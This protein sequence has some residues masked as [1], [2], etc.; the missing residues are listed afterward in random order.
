MSSRISI[1]TGASGGLGK[2]IARDLSRYGHVV[3]VSS[4]NPETLSRASEEGQKD[5]G[6]YMKH[7]L[8]IRD[9][10]QVNVLIDKVLEKY[11]RIDVLVNSAGFVHPRLDLENVKHDDLLDCFETNVFGL[12]YLLQRVVPIM[13]AQK[14]GVIINIASKSARFAV[15]GLGVY[16]ASKSA[17]LVLMQA[18]AKELSEANILCVTICPSGM[19]TAMRALVYG[20][21]DAAKQQ[22][23]ESVAKIV[24]EI[25]CKTRSVPQGA[26]V[27]V[28]RGE[29]VVNEM[30]NLP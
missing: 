27:D 17:S 7:A 12:F 18:L 14:S 10:A 25:V 28:I 30:P 24:Y 1:V 9:R 8:D 26:C 15:P 29:V 6:T 22:D 19:N 4:R 11:G 16:S 21:E 13:K 5:G 20:E 2:F 3:V 23:P